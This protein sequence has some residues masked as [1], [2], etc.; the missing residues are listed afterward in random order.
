MDPL[1]A[2]VIPSAT[3]RDEVQMRVVLPIA[4]MGLDDDDVPPPLRSL[5]L[6]RLKT[7]SK[8]RTPQRMNGLSKAFDC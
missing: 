3:R 4:A 8:H 5:P 7:S 6:T 2:L 1:L